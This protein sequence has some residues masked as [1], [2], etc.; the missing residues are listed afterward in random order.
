MRLREKLNRQ[1]L[2]MA[3]LARSL[4]VSHHWTLWLSR[5]SRLSP[6][7]TLHSDHMRRAAALY[8][9]ALSF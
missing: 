2:L 4:E 9:L 1:I 5:R 3:N 8:R 7:G 6:L